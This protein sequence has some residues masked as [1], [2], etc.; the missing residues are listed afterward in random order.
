[1][2][3]QEARTVLNMEHPVVINGPRRRIV[4]DMI[5]HSE[6]MAVHV[7][8]M[9]QIAGI[10]PRKIDELKAA[11]LLHDIGK[12]HFDPDQ[13]NKRDWSDEDRRIMHIHPLDSERFALL[14][15]FPQIVRRNIRG[16]HEFVD[17]TGYIDGL[18]EHQLPIGASLIK[19]ADE[20]DRMRNITPWRDFALTPE[21]ALVEWNQNFGRRYPESLRRVATSWYEQYGQSG[22]IVR[23]S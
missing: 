13:I 7:A 2:Y 1:M 23:S 15:G 21:Q 20:W 8:Q 18:K 5:E 4:P 10:T 6:R 3:E 19:L 16:H 17:G 22:E 9:A 12:V 11:T 14:H